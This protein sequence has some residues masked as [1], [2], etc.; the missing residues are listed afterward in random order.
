MN[1][2]LRSGGMGGCSGGN[3][4]QR[5]YSPP[6]GWEPK[7]IISDSSGVHIQTLQSK[8]LAPPETMTGL[9]NLPA[10]VIAR[11][12]TIPLAGT[13]MEDQPTG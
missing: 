2:D 1:W 6:K 7:I 8:D 11:V 5:I 9:E 13:V 3:L 4:E 10:D 12:E